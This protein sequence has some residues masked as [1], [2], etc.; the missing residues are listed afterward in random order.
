[1]FKL[2]KNEW[3]KLCYKK[4]T[5][6][7]TALTIIAIIGLASI[8]TIGEKSFSSQDTDEDWEANIKVS[9]ENNEDNEAMF[10]DE[11]LQESRAINEYRLAHKIAPP[12]AT[13]TQSFL[14]LSS[15]ILSLVLLFAAVVAAGIVANEFTDGTIK[16]LL[17][18]PVSRTKILL[19][20]LL[21]TLLF[22][23]FLSVISFVTAAIMGF[24]LFPTDTSPYLSYINNKVVETSPY[25]QA[26]KSYG[27]SFVQV[28]MAVLFAFMLGSVFRSSSL[29]IGLTIF[30][31]FVGNTAILF[32]ANYEYI[33]K[34]IWLAH[35]N[36][37]A[38]LVDTSMT[39][40]V[41]ILLIYA[42]LF[43]ALSF[44]T[45]NKRDVTA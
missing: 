15:S 32:L 27:F 45:F 10:S 4:A 39:F 35:T 33:T 26:L 42:I 24:I 17:T 22:A 18:R 38:P 3:T 14:N 37:R 41:M 36:L 21:T 34:Y 13:T 43:T 28:I 30:I 7:M 40:S 19:S 25:L 1:M 29:A 5:W 31:S 11:Q 9:L 8:I 12:S 20:K 23:V 6:V 16:M 2:I 44:I